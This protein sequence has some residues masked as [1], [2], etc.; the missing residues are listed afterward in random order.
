MGDIKP[1]REGVYERISPKKDRCYSYWN[2]LFS[3]WGCYV[4]TPENAVTYKNMVSSE[5]TLPWRGFTEEQK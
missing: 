1:E 3:F 5:Q 4:S 2:A